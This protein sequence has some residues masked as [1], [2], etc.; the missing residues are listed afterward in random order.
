MSTPVLAV[1]GGPLPSARV[2]SNNCFR[3]AKSADPTYTLLN[4]QWGQE[5][6]HDMSLLAGSTI[7]S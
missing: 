1:G 4:M 3:E 7:S 2:I 6:A 5:I